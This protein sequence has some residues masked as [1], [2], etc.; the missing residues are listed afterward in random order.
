MSKCEWRSDW[1]EDYRCRVAAEE[2]SKFCIFHEPGEK[3]G[4]HFK[5]AFYSQIREEGP[6][7]ERNPRRVRGTHTVI[8]R[9]RGTHTVIR[10]IQRTSY[11]DLREESTGDVVLSVLI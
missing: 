2:G 8:R 9:V 3:E 4:E 5:Q 6:T 11:C 10:T 1:D 7:D